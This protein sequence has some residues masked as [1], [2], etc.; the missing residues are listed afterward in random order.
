[1]Y[2]IPHFKQLFMEKGNYDEGF[3]LEQHKDKWANRHVNNNNDLNTNNN[4][5]KL[6]SSKRNNGCDV[7]EN[8]AHLDYAH[9]VADHSDD[10]Y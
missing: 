2:C 6:T 5:N 4:N 3:G 7:N 8:D 10:D 9:E 1:M